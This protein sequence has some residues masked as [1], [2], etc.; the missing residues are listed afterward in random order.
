MPAEAKR[1][2]Y[3]PA[4]LDAFR[5]NPLI[6]ALPNF[7][8]TSPAAVFRKLARSPQ[9]ISDWASRRQRARWLA[10]LDC[11]IPGMRHMRLHS[12]IDLMIRLGYAHKSPCIGPKYFDEA[13]EKSSFAGFRYEGPLSVVVIGSPGTGKTSGVMRVLS[14]YEQVID[15]R[16]PYVREPLRQVVYMKVEAP[17][18]VKALCTAIIAELGRLTGIDYA[19]QCAKPRTALKTLQARVAELMRL[20]RVGIL[21]L[22]DMQNLVENCKKGD[23]VRRFIAWLLKALD[24]PVLLIGTTSLSR[25]VS[26]SP[27][28]ASW[29]LFEWGRC[30]Q[31][32]REWEDLMGKL[33]EYQILRDESPRIPENVEDAFYRNSQGS[34]DVLL[35]LFVLSQMKAIL[36]F[37]TRESAAERLTPNLI[38]EVARTDL[39]DIAPLIR[40]L[41]NGDEKHI[42]RPEDHAT[43]S[44]AFM[45][46]VSETYEKI[47]EATESLDEAIHTIDAQN[48]LKR[49]FASL[50][51]IA[52]P[53]LKTLIEE[54]EM[55]GATPHD[56]VLALAGESKE[57]V[58]EHNGALLPPTR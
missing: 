58:I 57:G 25:F 49:H 56:I 8:E 14:L 26:S 32:S 33:R 4:S 38:D 44:D 2:R 28:S 10:E 21:V 45:N 41:R 50:K 15:H 30:E 42:D 1:T 5:G 20:H 39:A 51:R 48:A 24:V 35:K 37:C 27:G 12:I 16:P 6:E 11:F 3:T 13:R 53:D 17:D 55:R 43:L 31:N 36:K 40:A 29:S 52:P 46:A 19:A 7:L 34:I 47:I 54:M 9:P 23:G 18:T 22:D